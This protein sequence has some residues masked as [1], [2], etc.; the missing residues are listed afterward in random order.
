MKKMAK[1][2]S[3]YVVVGIALKLLTFM[4]SINPDVAE[5][6]YANF[7]AGLKA[8]TYKADEKNFSKACLVCDRL[9][10]WDDTEIIPLKRL[11]ALKKCFIGE[12]D[13][14]KMLHPNIKMYYTYKGHGYSAWMKDMFL[15]PRGYFRSDKQGFQCCT[16]CV[17]KLNTTTKPVRVK[18]PRF[19]IANGELFGDAPIELTELNDAELALVSKARTN[20][21]VFSF[22]GGAHKCMRGWHNL[23]ENDVEGIARTL[24]QVTNYGGDNVILCVLLGPFTP[25]QKQFC[26]NNMMVRPAFVLR[27]MR[28]LKAHNHL[29]KDITI[30]SPDDLPTPLIIDDSEDVESE[31]T[32]IESRLEYNVVFP[33]TDRVSSTNGGCMTQV[34]FQ[35]EVVDAMDTTTET[36]VIS[37][38]TTNRLIDYQGDALLRAFPLQFPYGVGLPPDTN[39]NRN[40][41]KQIAMSKLEYLHHLQ[42]LSIRHFHRG[43]FILVLHN[44]YERQRAV[45]VSFLRCK[46]NF[47]NDSLADHI[48]GMGLA[49][50]QSAINRTHAGLPVTDRL[51]KQFLNSIDAVCKSMGHTNEAA[52]SAR[53]KMLA[54]TV[55]FGPGAVFLTVTPDDGN[56]IRLQIYVKH[57]CD[58]PPDSMTAT[59]DE[60]KADFDLCIKLRQDY[61]GLCAFDF[62]QITELMIEHLFGWNRKEQVS[63]ANGGAFG[64]LD[65]FNVAVEEQGRKTLHSHWILYVQNWSRLLEGL[66]SK[67]E[68]QRTRA[69]S[70]LR[71]YVDTILSTKLFGLSNHIANECIQ[72]QVQCT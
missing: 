68:H 60:I 33:E 19:S 57:E 30:P 46:N 59:D 47:R 14:F 67:D 35:K 6:C 31:N 25:L 29:Y 12:T 27:A 28:W 9:L 52:K 56:C 18:L 5:Q 32:N 58:D 50:L 11:Q 65:A 37:R 49:Q 53:L 13:L 55:R 40:D 34:Q 69:A 26:K 42:H 17:K 51:T 38:P 48:A 16:D 2:C 20:K 62:Q 15:S 24:N 23:Y 70:D 7:Q 10:E 66:Y 64:V 1:L 63:H 41:G 4:E 21:H 61:P 39:S 3:L 45:S 71:S 22:Y 72:P 54:D 36:T 44:M 43:D 8:L